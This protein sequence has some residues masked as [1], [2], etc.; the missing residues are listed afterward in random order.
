M[1]FAGDPRVYLYFIGAGALILI[2]LLAFHL[3]REWHWRRSERRER[4]RYPRL[5]AAG[6]RS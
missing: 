3:L 5:P 2:Q 1:T 6:H 4:E